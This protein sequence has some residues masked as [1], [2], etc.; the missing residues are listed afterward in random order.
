MN[1]QELRRNLMGMGAKLIMNLQ[2]ERDGKRVHLSASALPRGG[3]PLV[4]FFSWGGV[5]AGYH[6]STPGGKKGAGHAGEK[7]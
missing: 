1:E 4:V 5:D 3:D 6:G 2:S 7:N